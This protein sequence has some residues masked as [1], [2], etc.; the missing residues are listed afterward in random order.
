MKK[1]HIHIDSSNVD[2]F[3][4]VHKN[5]PKKKQK[6]G[7]RL[8]FFYFWLKD[9]FYQK[10]PDLFPLTEWSFSDDPL[11]IRKNPALQKKLLNKNLRKL[12][13]RL[14]FLTP[15]RTLILKT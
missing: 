8:P 15:V 7:K 9:H 1:F 3:S 11:P 4:L 12:Y 5:I 14:G 10:S 6:T 13:V 2:T